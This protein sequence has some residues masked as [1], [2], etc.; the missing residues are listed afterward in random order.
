MTFFLT[1]NKYSCSIRVVRLQVDASV[2]Q[3]YVNSEKF[4]YALHIGTPNAIIVTTLG[5]KVAI[6]KLHNHWLHG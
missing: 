1:T 5:T 6:G 2:C 4:F 3:M